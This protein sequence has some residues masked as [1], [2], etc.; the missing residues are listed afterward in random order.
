MQHSPPPPRVSPPTHTLFHLLPGCLAFPSTPTKLVL[1]QDRKGL[2]GPGGSTALGAKP[3]G[4]YWGH[5]LG[6]RE[7]RDPRS[8]S[9]EAPFPLQYCWVHLSVL[10]P[11]WAEALSLQRR[12]IAR[13]LG[14]EGVLKPGCAPGLCVSHPR[15]PVCICALLVF[16]LMVL[17]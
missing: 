17:I 7:G 11:R 8:L 15:G 5:C 14:R 4:F 12:I 1:A 2:N 16:I 13:T 3:A 9:G 10:I 6:H